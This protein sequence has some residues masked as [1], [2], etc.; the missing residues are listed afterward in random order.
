MWLLHFLSQHTHARTHKHTN[1]HKLY[2]VALVLLNTHTPTPTLIPTHTTRWALAEGYGAHLITH[3]ELVTDM[4]S[5][6]RSRSGLPVSIKIRIHSD[7]R[8]VGVV[9]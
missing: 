3:P 8:S 9:I 2:T 4:I 7:L 5:Q 6:A 1:T